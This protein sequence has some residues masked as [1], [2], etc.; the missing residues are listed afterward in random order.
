M[1]PPP[2]RL[3]P[4][5]LVL[6]LGASALSGAGGAG[7]AMVTPLPAG[8]SGAAA[9]GLILIHAALVAAESAVETLRPMHLRADDAA[10]AAR[11]LEDKARY[12]AACNLAARAVRVL[13]L[14]LI[15]NIAW[16]A[17]GERTPFAVGSF[18]AALAGAALAIGSANLILGEIVP[19]AWAQ[20]HPV[21]T[22][23]RLRGTLNTV[24]LL[25]GFPAKL[26][27][28]V[29]G[30]FANRFGGR[31]SLAPAEAAE[32]EIKTLLEGAQ[33]SGAIEVDE[34]ELLDSVFEF[35][36][37]T[38]REV[39]TP[40]VDL[41]ALPL[42][43]DP[44]DVVR[45]VRESGHSRIP[46]Y[47]G[48]D[49]AIAGFIHAK[50]LL[51]AMADGRPPVLKAL[52]RP[53]LFV[54]E[55]K[56]LHEL[57]KEM[58]IAKAQMAVVQDEFGGTSGV[59]TTEDIVEELVGDIVDEYDREEPEV[60]EHSSGW[61]VDGKTHLDDVND[62]TGSRFESEEFDTVG[63]YVFGLFGRQPKPG[64][65]IES[66]GYRFSVVETDGRRIVRLRLDAL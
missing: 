38:A 17:T 12:A 23:V 24:S 21:S 5:A 26:I 51:L 13:L 18:L 66:E 6:L 39:M 3:H 49:D 7:E 30:L 20:L 32:E 61:I 64:E 37:K 29:A 8:A 2:K 16:G 19:R 58:R 56:N 27:V 46:L 15:L 44:A 59:V 55:G 35:T 50:D 52:L 40:R 33:E 36:D 41:E 1:A 57:I 14:A 53:V 4:R 63:G 54:H 11:Y 42:R 34:K 43:S 60:V 47:E 65:T 9:A 28:V 10:P 25:F 45:L 31:A 62:E 22:I 48:T